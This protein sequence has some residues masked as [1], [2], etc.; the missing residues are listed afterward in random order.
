MTD[1]GTQPGGVFRRQLVTDLAWISL[2]FLLIV[3]IR[4]TSP[5]D[6]LTGDQP[7][8]TAYIDDIVDRDAWLVQHASDGRVQTK[9]P[10]Y[11]WLA[12]VPIVLTGLRHEPLLKLP[13][14]LAALLTMFIVYDLAQERFGRR[15]AILAALLLATSTM[16]SK[17]LYFART[18]TLLTALIALQIWAAL[19]SR[20]RVLWV[21]AALALLTKG[22]IGIILPLLIL[23]VDWKL[24]GDLGARWKQLGVKRGMLLAMLPLVIWFGFACAAEG[25]EVYEQMVKGETID[26]FA[27]GSKS[28]EHRHL[29]WY[30]PHFFSRMAPASLFAMTVLIGSDSRRARELR[31][32]IVWMGVT[33]LLFS[34]VP[35]KRVDRILPMIPAVSILAAWALTHETKL[36]RGILLSFSLLLLSAAALVSVG[37]L[38]VI[39]VPSLNP[40]SV[41]GV[42]M[43]AIASSIC[44]AA[45]FMRGKSQ[46]A[47]FALVA[48]M[49]GLT[50]VYQHSFRSR[51]DAE[52]GFSDGRKVEG[53]S[54]SR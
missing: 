14:I 47:P 18:D 51:M 16:F 19:R 17:Q 20:P 53:P 5:S 46:L 54:V 10:L 49:I 1:A 30:V 48:A 4:A 41:A 35:S 31:L 33:L 52:R 15:A 44:I 40:I 39:V 26:R 32:F 12:A 8:Q 13:S 43:M 11:N 24:E 28:K 45:S 21:A 36:V 27:A 37:G 7:L 25:V 22:P 9:P 50:A 2:V 23:A 3:L 29:L 6:L 38:G 42:A 34:I